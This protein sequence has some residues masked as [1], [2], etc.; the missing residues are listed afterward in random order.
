MVMMRLIELTV[1][2]TNITQDKLN[3]NETVRI[4]QSD[5]EMDREAPY[6]CTV[7]SK[8]FAK[9]RASDDLG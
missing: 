6:F 5:S 3:A 7:R 2:V 8:E 4:L 1:R 9:V